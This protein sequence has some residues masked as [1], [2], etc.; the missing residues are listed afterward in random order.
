MKKMNT[1]L[2]ILTAVLASFIFI[3][4]LFLTVSMAVNTVKM[5]NLLIP[6][7]VMLAVLIPCLALIFFGKKVPKTAYVL[8]I[9]FVIGMAVY[10]VTFVASS[11]YTLSGVNCEDV[12]DKCDAVIIF[13]AKVNGTQPSRALGERLDAALAVYEKHPDAVFVV[14][15]GQGSDERISEAQCM[16]DYLILNGVPAQSIVKEELSTD[17]VTNIQNSKDLLG[18]MGINK[19]IVCV[20]SE[21]HI[22]R[23]EKIC[24]DEG[25]DAVAFGSRTRP[26]IKLWTNLVREYMSNI[27]YM[28]GK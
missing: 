24:S 19:N 21:Y 5:S 23:I 20:S 15:G 22:K 11:I 13:G 25:V 12:P 4:Y 3:N 1:V 9:V 14:S 6:A 2:N 16:E 7:A 28:I 18:K 8:Q 26:P 27:K 10:A 17:T